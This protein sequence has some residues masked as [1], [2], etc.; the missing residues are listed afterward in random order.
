M[1]QR[2][3]RTGFALAFSG[4]LGEQTEFANWPATPRRDLDAAIAAEATAHN[5]PPPAASSTGWAETT[6]ELLQRIREALS[7]MRSCPDG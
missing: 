2:P 1:R 7:R 6:P 3:P 4:E 5:R